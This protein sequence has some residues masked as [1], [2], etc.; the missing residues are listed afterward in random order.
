M[1]DDGFVDVLSVTAMPPRKAIRG[2]D[3][4]RFVVCG[5]S[6]GG[7]VSLLLGMK[8]RATSTCFREVVSS[9]LPFQIIQISRVYPHY[10]FLVEDSIL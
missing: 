3:Y 6:L 5:H 10:G 7:S 2:R 8:L 9:F 4:R 1:Q